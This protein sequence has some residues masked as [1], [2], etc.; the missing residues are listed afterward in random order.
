M[1]TKI[2]ISLF[3][4][5]F[6]GACNLPQFPDMSNIK[7]KEDTYANVTFRIK[8]TITDSTNNSPVIGAG[9]T[10]RR[11]PI[12]DSI[13]G[14]QTNNEGHYTIDQTYAWDT[15]AYP[16]G[17]G[18]LLLQIVATGYKTKYIMNN[19]INHVRITEKWQIIDVQLEPGSTSNPF[20]R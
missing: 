8:G 4:L 12:G 6:L 15:T 10:L 19:D 13:A 9:V 18:D 17:E 3:I 1:K 20:S 7:H 5:Y 11:G 14:A 16:V 2:L